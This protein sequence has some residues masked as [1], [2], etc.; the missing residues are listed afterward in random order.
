[1]TQ[2]PTPARNRSPEPLPTLVYRH[3]SLIRRTLGE[4]DPQLQ[5]NKA[6]NLALAAPCVDGILIPPGKTFSFSK[7][8]GN[9]IP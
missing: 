5:E 8:V 6:N 2:R 1:M 9:A 4:V 7:L 3:N